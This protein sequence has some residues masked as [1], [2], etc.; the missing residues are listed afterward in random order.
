MPK[1]VGFKKLL[2]NGGAKSPREVSVVENE[3][4]RL[5]EMGQDD[6]AWFLRIRDQGYN[7]PL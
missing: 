5:N 7:P 6:F 1:A 4:Y 2:A 3:T